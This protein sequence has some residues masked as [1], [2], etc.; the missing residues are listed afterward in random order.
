[1]FK[2]DE[3]LYR[4]N[5][6]LQCQVKILTAELVL[7]KKTWEER[8][9]SM[10]NSHEIQVKAWQERGDKYANHNANLQE[11]LLKTYEAIGAW[12]ENPARLVDLR[13]FLN[14]ALEFGKVE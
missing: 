12:I 4:E 1:M 13:A 5:L 7:L 11:R 10:G 14:K 3:K 6:D 9:E 2:R 8:W